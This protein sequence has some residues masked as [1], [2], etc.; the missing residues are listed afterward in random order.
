MRHVKTTLLFMADSMTFQNAMVFL[1]VTV[2]I[3]YFL[4]HLGASA[5]ALSLAPTIVNIGTIL[6]QPFFARRA[7]EVSVKHRRFVRYL[8]IQRVSFFLYALAIPLLYKAGA[9]VSIWAFLAAWCMFNCFTGCYNTFFVAIYTKMVPLS[10]RGRVMGLGGAAANLVA[11]LTSLLVGVLTREIAFP[12]NIAAIFLCGILL[13]LADCAALASLEEPEDDPPA[14]AS[15]ESSP[16]YLKD[17]LAALGTDER[18]RKIIIGYTFFALSCVSL[19]YCFMYASRTFSAPETLV[20]IFSMLTVL[21]TVAGN[22]LF[23]VVADR[24]GHLSTLILAGA[25]SLCGGVFLVLGGSQ[26]AVYCAFTLCTVGNA[27]YQL[28]ANNYIAL[29]CPGEKLPLYVSVHSMVTLTLAAAITLLCGVGFHLLGAKPIFAA[30]TLCA[31]VSI[32]ITLGIRKSDRQAP[33][34]PTRDGTLK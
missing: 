19:N 33:L 34:S 25:A 32:V 2:V 28:S 9:A 3:P 8:L 20:G 31:A 1:S 11:V 16:A 14:K 21:G 12:Y 15:S 18:F 27:G 10:Q 13:L 7:M 6:S 22:L 30:L 29:H 4:N 5:F 26:A 24:F 17:A 23:G